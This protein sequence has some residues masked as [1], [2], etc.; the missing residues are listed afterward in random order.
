MEWNWNDLKLGRSFNRQ[1]LELLVKRTCGKDLVSDVLAY[2]AFVIVNSFVVVFIFPPKHGRSIEENQIKSQQAIAY[3]G[4]NNLHKLT[5]LSKSK[6]SKPVQSFR[7]FGCW[8]G[9]NLRPWWTNI[10]EEN[11]KKIENKLIVQ[12]EI[13]EDSEPVKSNYDEMED[14]TRAS[15][16]EKNCDKTV[17]RL[18]PDWF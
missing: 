4:S 3:R 15:A 16:R 2:H 8:I 18:P 1:A 11:S 14:G 17:L 6:R 9:S 13:D 10:W 12:I 5:K 7:K